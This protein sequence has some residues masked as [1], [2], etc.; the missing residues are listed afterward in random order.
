MLRG[1]VSL[2]SALVGAGLATGC[3]DKPAPPAPPA[4]ASSA[5][6][7]PA[8]AP[9]CVSSGPG[10]FTIGERKT[11]EAEDG[12]DEV[13]LP[14][15]VEVGAAEPHGDGFAVAA[16]R[17]QAGKTGAVVALIGRDA[18][19]GKVVELGRTF[20]DAE[21]PRL[22]SRAGKLV[23]AVPDNDA[24]GGT[25][26]LANLRGSDV[27]WGADIEQGRD[28]SQVFDIELSESRGLLVWD[29][30]DESAEHGVVRAV[31]F[32]PSDL[33]NAT[34]PRTLSPDGDDAEAPRLA[35]RPG[36]Y[37]LAWISRQPPERPA[38]RPKARRQKKGAKPA[39][40]PAEPPPDDPVVDLGRRW[41]RIA[42]LDQNG[43][44]LAEPRDV[45][46][47]QA[48]VLVFDLAV[49]P[50]G[51]AVLAWRDDPT[52][53]GVERGAV[54]LARVGAGGAI[55]V[56]T[57]EDEA[58]GAGTPTIVVDV[59]PRPGAPSLW[60]A[61]GSITDSTR[62]LAL[63]P[64]GRPRDALA[65]EPAVGNAEPLAMTGG[66]LLLSRPRG[67]AVELSGVRCSPGA[68]PDG[69]S[70]DGG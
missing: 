31:S 61:L 5:R 3:K 11:S 10:S 67:L 38:D 41:L 29:E 44:L 8:A 2:L 39:P 47:R 53:P 65:G 36:G 17:T 21:A 19:S 37:W 51:G 15:A 12:G 63:G 13:A 58:V 40:E 20:G 4:A 34:R 23:L 48:H 64:D 54:H 26:R 1:R 45:T 52:S 24:G 9:R 27:T 49:L 28:E 32:E 57:L 55:E 25:L 18:D 14:F 30:W 56:S 42:P 50:S 22:A 60:L 68:P 59:A 43:A 70:G 66:R 35:R 7:A 69:G 33:G 46:G 6:A 62:L 16:L